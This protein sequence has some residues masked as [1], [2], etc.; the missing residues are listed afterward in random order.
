MARFSGGGQNFEVLPS[1][2]I[3]QVYI[4]LGC[5]EGL[6]KVERGRSDPGPGFP[7]SVEWWQPWAL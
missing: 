6:G 7:L 4:A 2:P 1:P 5:L 3:T